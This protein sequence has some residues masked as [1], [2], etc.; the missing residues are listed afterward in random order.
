MARLQITA[1]CSYTF[2]FQ[3]RLMTVYALS[4]QISDLQ[5]GL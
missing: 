4:F 3:V 2:N 5:F 1:D